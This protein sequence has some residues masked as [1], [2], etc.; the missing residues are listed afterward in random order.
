MTYFFTLSLQS[1]LGFCH[2]KKYF[3]R[4]SGNNR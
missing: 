2:G 4:D 1:R 3:C